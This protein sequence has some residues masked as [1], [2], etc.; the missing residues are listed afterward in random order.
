MQVVRIKHGEI[1]DQIAAY[2]ET[3]TDLEQA[4]FLVDFTLEP[5]NALKC[6]I[7]DSKKEGCILIMMNSQ[8][9]LMSGTKVELL[10]ILN[11]MQQRYKLSPKVVYRRAEVLLSHEFVYLFGQGAELEQPLDQSPTALVGLFYL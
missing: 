4:A 3:L 11:S 8:K 5:R 10:L 6:V 2:R 9:S 1:K 7:N